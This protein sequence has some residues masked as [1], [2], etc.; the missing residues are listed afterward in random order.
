MSNTKNLQELIEEDVQFT[1]STERMA[2]TTEQD[3]VLRCTM[4]V[5]DPVGAFTEL[6]RKLQELIEKGLVENS[7][8]DLGRVLYRVGASSGTTEPVVWLASKENLQAVDHANQLARI[9]KLLIKVDAE[10]KLVDAID[11]AIADNEFWA[12]S[13]L[14]LEMDCDDRAG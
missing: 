13:D 2:I 7:I 5:R 3:G 1:T 12:S 9:R 8:D 10:E 14:H 11:Q 6:Q 4:S